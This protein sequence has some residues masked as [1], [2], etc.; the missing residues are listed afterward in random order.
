MFHPVKSGILRYIASQKKISDHLSFALLTKFSEKA[1]SGLVFGGRV[2]GPRSKLTPAETHFYFPLLTSH[3]LLL[4][5]HFLLLTSYFLLL[6]SHFSLLTSYSLLLTPYFL[7]LTPH[8]SLLT[9]HSLL[10]T[11][12][13]L[14]LTSYSSLLTSHSLPPIVVPFPPKHYFSPSL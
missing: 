14:L 8:F 9:S 1:R 7:L 4:T 11:P 10:L 3:S 12:Y 13:S 5:P 2:A 6:T